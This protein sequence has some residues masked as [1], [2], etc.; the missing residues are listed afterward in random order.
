MEKQQQIHLAIKRAS[1]RAADRKHMPGKQLGLT[2]IVNGVA[3]L[4]LDPIG[5]CELPID[6]LRSNCHQYDLTVN[7][8]FSKNERVDN[9]FFDCRPQ[10]NSILQF[11]VGR[12]FFDLRQQAPKKQS[13]VPA[14]GIVPGEFMA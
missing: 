5:L 3:N 2:A 8:D 12:N 1:H 11:I 10:G 9:D 7:A 6:L 14:S 13:V 4:D